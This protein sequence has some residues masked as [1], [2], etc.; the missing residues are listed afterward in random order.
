[1]DACETPTAVRS[2]S[3]TLPP[4]N[5]VLSSP[6]GSRGTD[7]FIDL[8]NQQNCIS[9]QAH[10]TLLLCASMRYPSRRAYHVIY[11]ESLLDALTYAAE[12]NWNGIVPD[13]GVPAFSPERISSEERELLRDYSRSHSIEWGFH[14]PG[15]DVSLMTTYPPIRAGIIAYFKQVIDLAREISTGPT[16]VVVHAGTAPSFRTAANHPCDGFS[17][18]LREAYT[19]ALRMNLSE[20]LEYAQS[21]VRIAIENHGWNSSVREVI[22]HLIPQGLRLCLDIPK[23]YGSGFKMNNADWSLFERYQSSIEVVHI[24]DVI[25][26]I[27]SHQVVG[28]GIVDFE[29]IL[30]F[31]SRLDTKPQYVFEVRPREGAQRSLENMG[32][33]LDRLSLDL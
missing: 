13:I 19:Q 25:P 23:L 21:Y 7:S 9:R 16:G 32:W 5:S 20:L 10:K 12:T 30:R 11:D 8:L 33:M 6:R 18:K 15:D 24:H 29:P 3:V 14:A 2:L 27:G 28:D 17:E 31:L 22:E 26:Q 4:L 1:M